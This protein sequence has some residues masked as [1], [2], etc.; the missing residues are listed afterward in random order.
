M[1]ALALQR[2]LST[3]LAQDHFYSDF[4]SLLLTKQIHFESVM[5]I[6]FARHSLSVLT[7][8]KLMIECVVQLLSRFL[9]FQVTHILHASTIAQHLEAKL[10][11]SFLEALGTG[12]F[13]RNGI[14]NVLRRLGAAALPISQPSMLEMLF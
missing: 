4:L 11:A 14:R 9:L 1:I 3:V 7:S 2:L 8:V 6:A 13:F 5:M 10:L 12:Y